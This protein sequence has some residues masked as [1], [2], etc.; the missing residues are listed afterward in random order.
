MK[1]S[2]ISMAA[3]LAVTAAGL[4]CA[5]APE[6]RHFKLEGNAPPGTVRVLDAQAIALSEDTS[7]PSWVTVTRT[8]DFSD[9]RYGAFSITPTMLSQMVSNFDK[10]VTGQDIYID[11]A[12]KHSD[13]AAAK[14]L[15]LEVQDT[16]L[17]AL[18]EW[19]P[20]GVAA[21]KER[22][23]SYLSAEFHEAWTDNEKQ[24]AHGCVL[25]GA[26]L[27]IR[28]VIKHLDPVQLSAE[29]QPYRLLFPTHLFKQLTE[30]VMNKL[31]QALLARLITLG[32]S[33]TTAKPFLDLAE[34]QLA[35]VVADEAKAKKVS[36]DIVTTAESCVK[37]L[38]A[39]GADPKNVTITLA[40]ATG[41]ESAEQVFTRMLAERETAANTAKTTLAAKHKLLADTIKD[42]DKTLTEEGVKKFAEDYAPMITAASTDEQ[43]K[44][45]AS[46]AVKQAQALSAAKK[47]TGLGYN[48]AS[49]SVVITVEDHN[50]I[51]KL[52]EHVD[53]RL[54]LKNDK[55]EKRFERTGGELLTRNKEFAAKVL[56]EYDQANARELFAESKLLAAGSGSVSDVAV[57]KIAER[58]VLRES[59]YGLMSLGLVDVGTAPFANVIT[60]PYS[61]RDTTAAGVDGLRRYE[62]QSIQRA[63]IVQTEEETRPIPQK[64]A[65]FLSSEMRMLLGDSVINFEPVAENMRNMV[66]IVGE[67]VEAIN[68]NELARSADEFGATAV[69]AEALTAN[70]NG[71]KRIF[72]LANFPV[73]KPRKVYDLKGVQQG[74]TAN[75]IVVTL[76]AVVRNEYLPNADGT[77]LA[78]GLYYIMDYNL[79][80]IQFVT[81]AGVAS[82]PTNAWVL[83]VSYS[84]STNA[85]KFDTDLGGDAVDVHW[86]KLLF[87]IGGRKSVIEDER[88]YSPNMILMSGNINNA[89]SQAK[90][91]QANSA[92]VATGLASD[93]SV[94][95][96]KDM[97][98]WR[99]RSPRSGFGDTR[100]LVGERGTTRFRMI[101]P[102][103]V[104]PLEQARNA[105]GLF[106]DGQ[107]TFGTQW[108]GSHT[109]TQLKSSK[110]SVI[111]YSGTGRVAR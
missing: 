5:A 83:T 19:T 74:A 7:K 31:L 58:T 25:L 79:G 97:P 68:L 61:Y 107:E 85:N 52:Q 55:D 87:A 16:K 17:R 47:L 106:I 82:T 20:F 93:G 14:V 63:G 23:F 8:G 98:V 37:Q 26:G 46:L 88:Y 51:L 102:W 24:T 9:P 86:D 54:G 21:V 10:R 39:A 78:A 99:P 110:T 103:S 4:A 90:T 60:I 48:P 53:V 28:P 3:I 13:G 32:Y 108:V 42:G 71:V 104:N 1:R 75:P 89:L 91:F 101:K 57:P 111:L 41:G 27:T 36:D 49:G 70:V 84:Y 62:G 2:R 73:V 34:K 43:V 92:R 18:V 22:G 76:N 105:A 50:S 81:E 59:L 15:K 30:P 69:V 45:L 12:H 64:L 67:D 29:E 66:R 35:D 72:P 6:G 94:G 38:T 96:V 95:F 33:D 109:P 100:I 44:H 77:A 65:F 11:V 40:G 56:A 80:E